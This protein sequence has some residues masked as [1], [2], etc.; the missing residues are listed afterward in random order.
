MYKKSVKAQIEPVVT[1]HVTIRYYERM[2][3]ARVF[4]LLVVLSSAAIAKVIQKH[5]GQQASGPVQVETDRTLEIEPV[6]PGCTC[7]PP[8]AALLPTAADQTVNFW[9]VPDVLGNIPGALVR[10]TQGGKI[11]AEV[12]IQVRVTQQ[13]ATV[14]AGVTTMALPLASAL[15]KH[16]RLDLES[17][18]Q[19]GFSIYLTIL[20]TLMKLVP[21]PA[22]FGGLAAITLILYLMRRPKKRD[23][24]FDIQPE[25]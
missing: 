22:L 4:P 1:K 10:V 23:L 15:A 6:L 16:F 25:K 7:Y 2:N 3:P 13:T 11:I 19:D 8:K 21:T 12:P 18:L 20:N 9:V 14:L 24:F 17:Q 5:V